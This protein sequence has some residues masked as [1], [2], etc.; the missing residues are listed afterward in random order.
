[1][2]FNIDFH[3]PHDARH[4]SPVVARAATIP[5]L[6]PTFGAVATISRRHATEFITEIIAQRIFQRIP[7]GN[8]WQTKLLL[9]PF[10][11]TRCK[12]NLCLVSLILQGIAG[13]TEETCGNSK[14]A[15]RG[16]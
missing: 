4:K 8:N 9:V 15:E 13:F 12:S 6:V 5:F 1:V 14:Q 3:H 16:F 11:A 2:P 10:R 7:L